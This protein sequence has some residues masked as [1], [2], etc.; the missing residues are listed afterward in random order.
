ML[1][2]LRIENL[3]LIERAELR[4][5]PGL[6][7]ITGETGAGK[8][9]LAHSLDLLL[10]GKA[11][12]QIVRPG[13]DEAWVEGVFALPPGFL[14][15]PELAEIAARLP[16]RGDEL[17]LGR[18]IGASGRTSA[19]VGGRAASAADLQ[20]LG[21][22]LLAFYGQHQHRRL[23][24][25][26]AQ[27]EILD[28]FAGR[29]QL[30]LRDA[31]RTAHEEAT[32]LG[33]EQAELR[34][35]AG[36]RERDLDLLRFELS[37]IEAAAPDAAEAAELEA[38]RERLR[39]AE[40]LRA[41]AARALAALSG[42]AE[43]GGG[44]R[45][46]LGEADAGLGAVEG[47]DAELDRL[48]E[49]ARAVAV[50]LDDVAAEL[51]GYLEGFEAEPGRLERVGERLDAFERLKRKH[52][53]SIEA[54]L[55]HAAHCRAEID[56]LL[57]GAELAAELEGRIAEAEA[58]RARLARR[59]GA[60]RRKAA[61]RLSERVAQELAQLAMEGARLE[62]SLDP[63]PEGFGAAGA[64]TVEFMVATNPGMPISPLKEAA[65]GGELSRIMLA[66]TGLGSEDARRTLV[67]DEVDAGIGG[68]T[69]RAVGERLRRLGEAHQVVCIT[70]LPQVASRAG[71]HFTID[72]D[73]SGGEALAT[74]EEVAGDELVAE[75]V[76]M[77]GAEQGDSTASRHALELLRAA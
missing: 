10:G 6:N 68:N 32:R 15:D 40:S 29:D 52:G 51:R 75:I 76:R 38:E 16:D 63:H 58:E 21:G 70:H 41:A 59:L 18:R 37:E 60:G 36:A 7:A 14:D 72:K 27:L 47:V 46:A 66:L 57:N 25:A 23:M 69:A 1:S 65:S 62:I 50:E 28:G 64:E 39:H 8:T 11:R 45:A 55:A 31:Y 30:L 74:V 77:L 71:T 24:L 20:A 43:D 33:R 19:F 5:G 12:P 17:V 56:R 2:E 26:S 73:A 53:G 9:V 54:V 61:A 22:R 42:E 67:F 49:R 4:F 3:L 13:A 34:D 35:R 48:G 44:A